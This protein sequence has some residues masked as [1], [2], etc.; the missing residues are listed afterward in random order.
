MIHAY[1]LVHDDLP[2]M[3]NDVL[4]PGKPTCHV[5]FGETMALLAGDALQAHAFAVL[6]QACPRRGRCV[7]AAG[8]GGPGRTAWR[9]PG[10]R[11]GARRRRDDLPALER[12]HRMKTGALIRAAV[13]LGAACGRR[14][15]WKRLR[16]SM[17]SRGRPD[18]RSRSSTTCWTSKIRRDAWQDRRQGRR[19][20]SPRT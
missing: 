2:C 1:S 15:R 10:D 16:H 9:G 12:M 3:D 20:T 18:S 8:A 19:R 4:R 17:R 14:S 11:L 13:R 5:A 6:V 7:R